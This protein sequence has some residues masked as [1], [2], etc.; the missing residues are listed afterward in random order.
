MN[1]TKW[2]ALRGDKFCVEFFNGTTEEFK[3]TTIETIL[4]AL[5]D[6]TKVKNIFEI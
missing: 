6:I 2:A 3:H 4:F 5:V 1:D